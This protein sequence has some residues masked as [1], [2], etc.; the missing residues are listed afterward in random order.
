[1]LAFLPDCIGTDINEISIAYCRD[2]GLNAYTMTPDNLPFS[3]S[4]FDAVLMD[5]VLEHIPD[6]TLL[7]A[8]IHRVIRP[9]G[10]LL[11]G[12]PGQRGWNSDPDHKV[13]YDEAS[14]I[15]R[16]RQSHFTPKEIFFTPLF[17]SPVLAKILR[18]YCIYGLF[19][20]SPNT[21]TGSW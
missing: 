6:P 9:K 7:L 2:K 21:P 4:S 8:E 3:D 13:F 20:A 1:M 11:I 18:Q 17:R 12:V 5:N 14:L 10:R 16:L 15:E 19:E